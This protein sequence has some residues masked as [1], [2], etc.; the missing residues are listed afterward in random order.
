M[1]VNLITRRG[2]GQAIIFNLNAIINHVKTTKFDYIWVR[3]LWFPLA[4]DGG[5][6]Y[7]LKILLHWSF[8]VYDGKHAS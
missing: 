2:I 3:T 8:S 6:F 5:V 1:G 4:I 7:T